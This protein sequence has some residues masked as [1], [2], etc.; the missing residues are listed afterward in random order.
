MDTALE[1]S[2]TVLLKHEVRDTVQK[3]REEVEALKERRFGLRRQ[4]VMPEQRALQKSQL[5]EIDSELE[6]KIK[7]L[8]ASKLYEPYTPQDTWFAGWVKT[9]FLFTK[10][11][12]S[13][14]GV[15]IFLGLTF[16][17][18]AV[19]GS[20]DISSILVTMSVF[21]F[22]VFISGI[23]YLGI[24]S[25]LRMA[26]H[27]DSRAV[28]RIDNWGYYLF[29]YCI[30]QQ[31]LP[32]D[33]ASRYREAERQSM[34]DEILIFAPNKDVF[35]KTIVEKVDPVLVGRVLRKDTKEDQYFLIAA[36]NLNE[37]FDYFGVA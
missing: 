6:Y 5:K 11:S 24:R 4:Y 28:R 26:Y 33:M 21:G 22:L 32:I 20:P 10:Q 1:G 25:D 7:L 14:G 9:P 29:E 36:W 34:F 27:G 3:L 13:L 31:I 16:F 12:G 18:G 17:L 15:L 37:D 30:F 35:K 2:K 23:V 8:K 19:F